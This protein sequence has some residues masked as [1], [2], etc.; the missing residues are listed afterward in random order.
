MP[1][2]LPLD[3]KLP[4]VNRSLIALLMYRKVA[5]AWLIRMGIPLNQYH[6]NQKIVIRSYD[7]HSTQHSQ[8][9]V[10]T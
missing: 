7:L 4:A 2:Q 5:P 3:M 8:P 9:Q 10:A 6:V 1:T